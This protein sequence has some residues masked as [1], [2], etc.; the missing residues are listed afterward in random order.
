MEATDLVLS[1]SHYNL[2][3]SFSSTPSLS[4]LSCSHLFFQDR[5]LGPNTKSSQPCFSTSRAR[6]RLVL[7]R[8]H[9]LSAFRTRKGV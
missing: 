5:V 7:A 2:S 8:A 6:H 3:L 4:A 1:V 9:T